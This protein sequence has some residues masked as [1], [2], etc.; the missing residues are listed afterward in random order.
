M[1]CGSPR[2]SDWLLPRRTTPVPPAMIT[3]P[4][5]SS[6]GEEPRPRPEA[7]SDLWQ[8]WSMHGVSSSRGESWVL[9]NGRTVLSALFPVFPSESGFC[10]LWKRERQRSQDLGPVGPVQWHLPSC[11]S[12]PDGSRKKQKPEQ[13]AGG[14]HNPTRE[15]KNKTDSTEK[16]ERLRDNQRGLSV[17]IYNRDCKMV[18]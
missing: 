18:N 2:H 8:L 5:T 16:V 7:L 4:M 12:I 3:V 13:G 1:I 10:F 15:T 17:V 9:W 6:R 14:S 11:S